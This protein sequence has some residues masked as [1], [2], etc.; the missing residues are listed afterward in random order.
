MVMTRYSIENDWL[1]FAN[2]FPRE[3]F[4]LHM[5]LALMTNL[6][7]HQVTFRKLLK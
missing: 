1:F 2:T 5:T 4:V 6:D 3:G 7:V